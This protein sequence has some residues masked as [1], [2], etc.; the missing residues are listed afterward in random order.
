M[1]V[2]VDDLL[3]HVGQEL[4]G[5]FGSQALLVMLLEHVVLDHVL[6]DG[7][8]ASHGGGQ[9][10]AHSENNLDIAILAVWL[11]QFLDEFGSVL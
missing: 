2:A 1:W 6:Q 9:V 5:N 7:R 10:V 3:H 4:I 8:L 11:N